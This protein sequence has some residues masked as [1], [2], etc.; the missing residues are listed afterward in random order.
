MAKD[1]MKVA[2]VGFGPRGLAALEKLSVQVGLGD[3]PV[4]LDIFDPHAT[5]AAGPNFSPTEPDVCL[6]N[7][8][9]RDVDLPQSPNKGVPPFGQWVQK[10]EANDEIYVP[11]SVLGTYFTERFQALMANLPDGLKVTLRPLRVERAV[12]RSNQWHL[13]AESTQFG[14]YDH[15]LLSLGQPKTDL[16]DQA[17]RWREHAN[18]QGLDFTAA[19]PGKALIQSASDWAGRAVAIRGLGLSSLDVIGMLTLGLGGQ[20]V[21]GRY[22]ASGREPSVLVPFSLD[23]HA[24]APKPAS[25][26]I[27]ALF[28]PTENETKSFEAALRAALSGHGDEG[29]TGIY[30]VLKPVV[31]R[32]LS[33]T[34]A[35]EDDTAIDGWLAMEVEKPGRQ[36]TRGTVEA[37]EGNLKEA[38]GA[39]PP[40]VGFTVGQVWRKWQ[41]SLRAFF[42]GQQTNPATAKSLI[43]FDEGLKRY[44]Y[45][46]PVDNLRQL[47]ILI[48]AGLVTPCAAEDPS[49]ELSDDG[50]RLEAD[51][52]AVTA[53]VMIDS[54][55]PPPVIDKVSEPVI[56]GLVAD[57]TLA[58]IYDGAGAH[59]MPDGAVIDQSGHKVAGLAIIGRLTNGSTIADDSIHDCF[60]DVTERWARGVTLSGKQLASK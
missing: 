37:I 55:L 42:D 5:P 48:D 7:L 35:A 40:S 49:I 15:V 26:D 36:E 17:D 52:G 41:P 13:A 47:L 22:V 33:E 51:R 27:D 16:D 11:R 44:S 12:R 20:F 18:S 4:D 9:I 32:I 45:G 59:C 43:T 24:P 57:G 60:G 1:P 58:P 39:C 50:W 46:A 29:L 3:C 34:G 38:E 19:Y 30:E 2:I 56:Q 31:S 53:S 25:R 23:G 6:L 14:P 28:D 21:D 8:P 10:I 54:V